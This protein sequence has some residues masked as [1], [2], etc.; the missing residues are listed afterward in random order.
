M[1]LIAFGPL[2]V[3]AAGYGNL[4][5]ISRGLYLGTGIS[6]NR[7]GQENDEVDQDDWIMM[8]PV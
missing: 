7:I 2:S 3:P 6:K 8:A 1:S 4:F 5:S